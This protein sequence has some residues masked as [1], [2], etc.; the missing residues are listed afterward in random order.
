MEK[1][2]ASSAAQIVSVLGFIAI[3]AI[4]GLGFAACD[5]GGGGTPTKTVTVGMQI[6]TLTAGTAGT[7]TYP[8]TTA[9]IA[10]GTYP[11]T[12]ANLPSGVTVGNSGNVTIN[13][14]SCT[15][16]LAAS[17][18]V[19]TATTSNLTLTLDGITS[20]AF[21]IAIDAPAFV[22]EYAIGDTG[23]GGGKII[24][25]SASG[26]NVTG[27]GTCHYLEAAPTNQSTGIT[28][29]S[30]K[31]DVTG[32]AGTAIGTGKANTAAII[33]AH[34]GDTASNNAAKAVA[35]YTG[36]G[37]ND[38]FLPSKDE[39]NEMYKAR[40]HL[41]ISS[42]WFWSSSQSYHDYAWSQ[43]FGEGIQ[44]GNNQ[45][46]VNIYVRAVRAF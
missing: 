26:F 12:V 43:H 20:A 17:A 16:T 25:I 7:V 13:G 8:V 9:N 2:R 33:A 46:I 32:A 6:G 41:G 18:S 40:S 4:I 29:S 3:V 35:A 31:V 23:P 28:W 36:S 27:L 14:N 22:P 24:Y 19:T 1:T 21:T 30:T 15:L 37:K 11:V 5:D 10:N 45:K 44:Y 42:E 39:L 34:S 38:W